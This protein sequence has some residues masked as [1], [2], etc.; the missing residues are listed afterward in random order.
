MN[1]APC[2]NYGLFYIPLT[3]FVFVK[4]SVFFTWEKTTVFFTC[5]KYGLFF[6]RKNYGLFYKEK[7][8]P[9]LQGKTTAFF[10]INYSLFLLKSTVFF[11]KNYK[12]RSIRFSKTEIVIRFCKN[13]SLFYMGKTTVF[14]TCKK[15]GLFLQGKTTVFFTRKNYGLF[16]YKLQSFFI[17]KYG[18]FL[19]KTIKHGV[20]VF[21]K[22]RNLT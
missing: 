15:Y 8:R 10:T 20:Y 6:T 5:K 14:F 11:I 18:I 17:E 22:P 13:F 7:L 12:A 4:T 3:S 9:F 21:Q 16:Y 2:K 19:L 1:E